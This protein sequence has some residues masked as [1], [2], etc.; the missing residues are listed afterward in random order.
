MNYHLNMALN[1]RALLKL[2]VLAFNL[3]PQKKHIGDSQPTPTLPRIMVYYKRA[4]KL[5]ALKI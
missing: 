3:G 4:D 2:S 5:I 1:T